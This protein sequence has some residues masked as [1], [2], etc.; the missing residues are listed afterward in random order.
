M[1]DDQVEGPEEQPKSWIQIK[2]AASIAKR[3]ADG[4]SVRTKSK[5]AKQPK[6][7]QVEES[8]D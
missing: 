6:R 5:K 4:S 7:P 8:K 1:Q 3:K 2:A